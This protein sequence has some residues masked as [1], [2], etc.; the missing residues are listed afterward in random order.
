M[1]LLF[2]IPHFFGVL[3]RKRHGSLSGQRAA[4]VRALTECISAIHEVLAGEQQLASPVEPMQ[5]KAND[6]TVATIDVVVC[7]TRHQHVLPDMPLTKEWYRE[8]ACQCEPTLLGFECHAVLRDHL[9]DYDYY[10]YLEDDLVLRDPWFF[11]KLGHFTQAAGNDGLL[12]PNRYEIA[13]DVHARKMYIDGDLDEQATSRFQTISEQPEVSLSCLGAEVVCRRVRNPH[14]G[15]FFLSAEQMEHWSRQAY[16]LDRDTSFIGPL[17][18]AAT[19]G[20]MRTFRV[21]KPAAAAA[22]F[23]EIEH[24]G[25]A[26]V[27]KIDRRDSALGSPSGEVT[28]PSAVPQVVGETPD[29]PE[30]TERQPVQSLWIGRDLSTMERLSIASFLTLGH[31]FHLYVYDEIGNVPEGTTLLDANSLV[32]ES[33]VFV[34]EKGVG[35]G[36]YAAFSD[37]FRCKL[38]LEKGEWWV[39]L[40]VVALRPFEFDRDYVLGYQGP[41]EIGNAVI[42][43]PSGCELMQRCFDEADRHRSG[44]D[45]GEMGPDLLTRMVMELDLSWA[46]EPRIAF[47]PVD[48]RQ[49]RRFVEPGGTLSRRSYAIHLIH[50]IWLWG[51]QD[52]DAQFPADCIYEKLKRR[53]LNPQERK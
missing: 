10:C 48:W 1:R 33:E 30:N 44:I 2:A 36:S 19:L 11:A 29:T 9:G 40:D 47:H 35:K 37:L 45:W 31:P 42:R 20:I 52:P 34:Y 46:A 39:D 17:E 49:G 8:V 7:T 53:Y 51:G 21:Y 24:S 18:S 12:Q 25:E 22:N 38:L 3:Q 16:F 14:S 5:M 32:P 26:W 6:Q 50:H 43:V 27:R 23:L 4:R 15:C 41:R 13:Q 28:G